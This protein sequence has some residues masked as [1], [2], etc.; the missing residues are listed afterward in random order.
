VRDTPRL[1]FENVKQIIPD[2]QILTS[3][4]FFTG[5]Q[6]ILLDR[7]KSPVEN[8]ED[9]ISKYLNLEVAYGHL[10]SDVSYQV[11]LDKISLKNCEISDG[12][13]G[14]NFTQSFGFYNLQN[15]KCVVLDENITLWGSEST[16]YW[17]F[18]QYSIRK[19]QNVSDEL[20][21]TFLSNYT[22]RM[23]VYFTDLSLQIRDYL[24][25]SKNFISVY[26]GELRSKVLTDVHIELAKVTVETDYSY[27]F[28]KSSSLAQATM[29][30]NDITH[31]YD[32]AEYDYDVSTVKFIA[33]Q[34]SY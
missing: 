15:A 30:Y 32:R 4:N 14:V 5:I 13:R 20:F 17:D 18:I 26:S 23:E 29:H 24:L 11:K 34:Y 7:N 8:Q 6:L 1:L 3:L 25:P 31:Y 12:P 10:N 2:R 16:G 33:S 22:C 28:E 9:I 19:N 27:F 21:F